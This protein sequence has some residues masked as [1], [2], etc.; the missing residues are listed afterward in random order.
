MNTHPTVVVTHLN[1]VPA[2]QQARKAHVYAAAGNAIGHRIQP[3]LVKRIA[4]AAIA[5]HQHTTDI[6]AAD[7]EPH[8]VAVHPVTGQPA[9]V[10][11]VLVNHDQVR[12][13]WAGR[14]NPTT[15]HALDDW[16][17]VVIARP[18]PL[19]CTRPRPD[20]LGECRSCR[21]LVL[22]HSWH[23]GRPGPLDELATSPARNDDPSG[24]TV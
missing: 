2:L 7:L 19:T 23:G 6:T 8:D 17:L 10:V 9:E 24:W 21:R 15:V 5:A 18:E 11:H 16:L 13:W 4:D 20:G 22:A 12:V 1:P 3:V 14:D